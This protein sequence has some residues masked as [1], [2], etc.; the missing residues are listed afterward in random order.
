MKDQKTRMLDLLVIRM[1]KLLEIAKL[2][3]HISQ[4]LQRSHLASLLLS[5]RWMLDQTEAVKAQIGELTKVK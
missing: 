2:C 3:N 5:E 1:R 4:T